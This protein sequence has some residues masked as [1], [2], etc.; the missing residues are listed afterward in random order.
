MMFPVQTA[1]VFIN[2]AVKMFNDKNIT[3]R[4]KIIKKQ[5]I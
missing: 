1:F 5:T 4:L 2:D 3:S